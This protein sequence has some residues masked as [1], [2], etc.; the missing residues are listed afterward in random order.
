MT[1]FTRFRQVNFSAIESLAQ[2]LKS[3]LQEIVS[4]EK[5]KQYFFIQNEAILVHKLVKNAANSINHLVRIDLD[6]QKAVEVVKTV[7]KYLHTAYIR[8]SR[9]AG[10][11]AQKVERLWSEAFNL[12]P[13][14]TI[15]Q[16]ELFAPNEVKS[17]EENKTPILGVITKWFKD[18]AQRWAFQQQQQLDKQY[19]DYINNGKPKPPV[20]VQL[21]L[22]LESVAPA[23]LVAKID[24]D[25]GCSEVYTFEQIHCYGYQK[26][27]ALN[28]HT[29]TID[30]IKNLTLRAARRLASELGLPQKI[31]GQD[32]RKEALIA[33]LLDWWQQ[34]AYQC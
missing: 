25:N 32:L 18:H 2:N 24:G 33:S 17:V 27:E 15:I 34:Q 30:S 1:V 26:L 5:D 6:N 20:A 13:S 21:C 7:V 16:P 4:L 12:L 22:D 28:N 19:F 14:G 31:N 29:L 11:V 8:V 3:A 10:Y 23:N 9:T